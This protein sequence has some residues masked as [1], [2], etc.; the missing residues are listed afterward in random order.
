MCVCVELLYRGGGGGG[1]RDI[2]QY[3]AETHHKA[4]REIL[5]FH[6]GSRGD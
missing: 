6:K 2:I 4:T 1:A 3:K 5:I